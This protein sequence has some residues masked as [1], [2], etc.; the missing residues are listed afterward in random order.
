MPG[1]DLV[2]SRYLSEEIK[3][4]LDEDILKKLE[5]QLFFEHGMSIK[6]S[7][8]HF[9]KFDK[10]LKNYWSND[11]EKFEKDCLKK[12]IQVNESKK[13]YNIRIINRN[14]SEKIFEYYGDPETRCILQC[15]MC[16]SLTISEIL[17]KSGV[18]KSP[19]YRKIENL[20]LDGIILESGK[21]LTNNKRV[22]QYYC[23]FDEVSAM[24]SKDRIELDCV[25]NLKNFNSSSMAKMGL[26]RN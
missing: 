6:L 22:S 23:I 4:Q 25:V 21:I 3:N 16:K 5:K 9:D 17:K 7:I 12:V 13:N 24:I 2:V 15:I 11:L 1:I 10:I 8:E 14:L 18:L 20:L 26:F 19:L